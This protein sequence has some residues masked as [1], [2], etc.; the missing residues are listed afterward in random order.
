M[1]GAELPRPLYEALLKINPRLQTSKEYT[2]L[3]INTWLCE[4]EFEKAKEILAAKRAQ[5]CKLEVDLCKPQPLSFSPPKPDPKSTALLKEKGFKIQEPPS[6][7]WVHDIY[8][9]L[10]LKI[11]VDVDA[12][13]M[14]KDGILKIK[15]RIQHD[16][17]P[18]GR[19]VIKNKVYYLVQG[20]ATDYSKM[21]W[22]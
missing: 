15:M 12:I 9:F 18:V 10:P 4:D 3:Y 17:F 11:L 22:F 20:Q 13:S 14:E 2:D 21:E 5:L 7:E 19:C 8:A 1:W 6:F 16:D